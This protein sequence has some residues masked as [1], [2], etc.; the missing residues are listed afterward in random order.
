MHFR[1]KHSEM[2]YI[3]TQTNETRYI[4]PSTYK[5]NFMISQITISQGIAIDCAIDRTI[6]RGKAPIRAKK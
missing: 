3:T 2:K 4:P 6:A 5:L 1:G